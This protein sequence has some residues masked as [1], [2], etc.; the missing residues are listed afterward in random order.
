[1]PVSYVLE[2]TE[3]SLREADA[4]NRPRATPTL[5]QMIPT[6]MAFCHS[7]KNCIWPTLHA[8]MGQRYPKILQAA[9]RLS[10]GTG[11]TFWRSF[12]RGRSEAHGAGAQNRSEER[13]V[14]K[15]CRSRWATYH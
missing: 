11:R 9:W 2:S 6:T 1:M 15:E 13:R 10:L 12:R 4:V 8:A 14:G 5:K 3:I 7:C